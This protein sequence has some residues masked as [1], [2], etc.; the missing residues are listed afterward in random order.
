MPFCADLICYNSHYLNSAHI[1]KCTSE[2]SSLNASII[3]C[4]IKKMSW[5]SPKSGDIGRIDRMLIIKFTF[6]DVCSV[7][8]LMFEFISSLFSFD[9]H[10]CIDILYPTFFIYVLCCLQQ[11]NNAMHWT[12]WRWC[13][14]VRPEA[15]TR[16]TEALSSLSVFI[17]GWVRL[18][19]LRPPSEEDWPAS[20]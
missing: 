9:H 7:S 14:L 18:P 11:W 15:R 17:R 5:F 16:D 19:V 8:V 20:H 4:K 12:W 3:F 10:E 6:L 1:G 13:N 2:K